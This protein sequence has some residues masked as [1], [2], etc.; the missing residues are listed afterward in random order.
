MLELAE[1]LPSVFLPSASPEL[2]FDIVA[3]A[4]ELAVRWRRGDFTGD[5]LQGLNFAKRHPKLRYGLHS[6]QC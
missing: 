3:D 5:I 1:G 6:I 4:K 2:P